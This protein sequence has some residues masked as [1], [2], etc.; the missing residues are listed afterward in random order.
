MVEGIAAFYGF[1]E[2][3]ELEPNTSSMEECMG[4]SVSLFLHRSA[5]DRSFG[6]GVDLKKDDYFMARGKEI[7][8]VHPDFSEA[9][10]QGLARFDLSEKG[11][12]SLFYRDDT[13]RESELLAGRI[14]ES[15]P[16]LEVELLYGG[17]ARGELILSLE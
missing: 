13:S 15:H 7:L 2:N 3:E 16:H 5:A 17:Q 6:G 14:G 1:S 9:V 11:N 12:L 8:S 4:F 10:M